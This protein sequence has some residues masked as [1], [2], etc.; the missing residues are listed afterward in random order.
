VRDY[1]GT[2]LEFIPGVGVFSA[3]QMALMTEMSLSAN[4]PLNWNVLVVQS[5]NEN[6]WRAQLAA[7]DYAAER[8]ATVVALTPSQ[9][10][11]LRLNLDTGFIFD[12]FP[13]WAPIISLPRAEKMKRLADPTLRAQLE[14]GAHSDAAG[15]L[16]ALAVW[17]NM[18][19]AE[20]FTAAN[21]SYQGRKLGEVAAELGKKPFDAM[22]DIAISED[23]RTSFEPFIPGDDDA[24]WKLRSDVWRDPRTLVGA[25]DAGAHLDMI[26]TFMC[27]T[28]LLG[29][30]VREKGLISLEE[31]VRQLTDV[32]A[33]HYGLRER[34][35]LE[36]GWHAD[37]TIFDPVRV[38]PGPIHTRSDL[39]EG[40][41]RLYADAYGIEHVFVNGS[42]IVR[43]GEL[44][45]R[46]PGRILRSG[47]DTETVTVPGGR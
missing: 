10:M 29:P 23:L 9:V 24:S 36:P 25:S 41:A 38:G 16:R 33:R 7:S 3:E 31:A 5:F 4:R 15:V 35:R 37:I 47:R 32:P 21:K 26:N 13:G 44:T 12:T 18:T 22:L 28:A 39:P 8:G 17:E 11:A 42:E 27:T 6:A 30:A 43:S 46:R 40:A 20:T 45:G 19:L 14:A 2:T 34:G 1:P